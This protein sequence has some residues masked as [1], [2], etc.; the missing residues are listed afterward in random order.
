MLA[1]REEDIDRITAAV[2][3]LNS[4]RIPAEIDLPPDCPDNE[5][6]QLAEHVNV[7]IR[8]HS[9]ASALA[10]SLARGN[11]AFEAPAGRGSR[12][13]DALKTLQASLR[14]LTWTT[15][16]IAEGDLTRKVDFMGQFSD[17]FNSMVEQLAKSREMLKEKLAAE[18]A[19]NARK[20]FLAHMSHE[21]RT[22]LNGVLG[23]I[24]LVLDS[25]LTA[26]Q[27][28]FAETARDSAAALLRI[29]N[30][31]LLLSKL[32]SGKTE[33]SAAPFDL[34]RLM[35]EIASLMRPRAL[36]KSLEFHLVDE[37]GPL[38]LSG[39]AGRIRQVILNLLA[40]AIKFTDTGRVALAVRRFPDT[41]GVPVLA[42]SVKDTGI[43]IPPEKLSSVFQAFVQVDASMSRAREGTGLGL[44]ISK[45]LA[46]AMGGSIAL[47]SKLGSGSTFTLRIPL[48]IAEPGEVGTGKSQGS[49]EQSLNAIS[50][51]F[52]GNRILLVEDN[53]VNQTVAKRMLE[54]LGCEV[55]LAQNGREAVEM[56]SRQAYDL[57]FM[58]CQMPVMDGY[59]ATLELRRLEAALRHTPVVAMTAHVLEEA[60]LQCLD[61]GMD[62]YL[63]KPVTA[64]EVRAALERWLPDRS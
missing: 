9:A 5:L 7:A 36:A 1:I 24:D 40:N 33:V 61:S 14:H 51:A 13:A 31:I 41:D 62:D 6:R 23:M 17:S 59:Q 12:I 52:D 15:Q 60:R 43:G 37:A 18:A 50:R 20:E 58:D 27:R 11:L 8:Q 35:E 48:Q 47:E 26:E 22:P 64:R 53:L 56:T 45:R 29:V 38:C 39:D 19:H 2:F 10:L 54:K 42:I 3:A 63:S 32:E 21:I 49:F 46:E 34:G 16:Q 57:V 28:G 30:D 55:D 44:A 25:P 4:G